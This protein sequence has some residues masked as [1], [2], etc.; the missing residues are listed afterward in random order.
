[1]DPVPD[2]L[3]LRKYGSAGNRTRDLWICRQKLWPLDHRGG[4]KLLKLSWNQSQ[5]GATFQ[6][7]VLKWLHFILIHRNS[8]RP[9]SSI[10]ISGRLTQKGVQFRLWRWYVWHFIPLVWLYKMLGWLLCFGIMTTNQDSFY[11]MWYVITSSPFPFDNTFSTG[12]KL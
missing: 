8:N 5:K 6:L 7:A 11:I 1:V 12:I 10:H 9:A 3:R 4:H 2:P